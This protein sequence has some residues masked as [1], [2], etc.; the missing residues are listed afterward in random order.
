MFSLGSPLG[1]FL[2]LR[3]MRPKP[4]GL[5]DHLLPK[6]LCKRFYNI[7]HPSDPVVSYNFKITFAMDTTGYESTFLTWYIILVETFRFQALMVISILLSFYFEILIF[8][9]RHVIESVSSSS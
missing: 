7:Y 8:S 2:T 3:G 4:N 5:M 6:S 1:V 9:L